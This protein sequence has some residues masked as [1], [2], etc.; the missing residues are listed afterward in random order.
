MQGVKRE[1]PKNLRLCIDRNGDSGYNDLRKRKKKGGDVD[2]RRK[3][4]Q[5][6]RHQKWVE[7]N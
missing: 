4:I 6:F 3:Q 5:V 2:V 7:F 1:F